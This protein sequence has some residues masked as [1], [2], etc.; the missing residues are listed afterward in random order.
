[1]EF[2]WP[3][4]LLNF[5]LHR[6]TIETILFG[7]ASIRIVILHSTTQ[8]W[9]YCINITWSISVLA[10]CECA[11]AHLV[12]FTPS[13]RAA[14]FSSRIFLYRVLCAF[15]KRHWDSTRSYKVC[16]KS[17]INLFLVLIGDDGARIRDC[18]QIWYHHKLNYG[19]SINGDK[20]IH[21]VN[22][23]WIFSAQTVLFFTARAPSF[24]SKILGF[25]I[26]PKAPTPNYV[27]TN[28]HFTE[29]VYS[30]RVRNCLHRLCAQITLK[31]A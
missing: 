27:R 15:L 5:M 16:P 14:H 9:T 12:P 17:S 31:R 7:I 8:T 24:L 11:C 13:Q 1:M 19:Q 25:R 28:G 29:T 26:L 2:S 30:A 18:Y 21:C 4:W 10:A 6:Q 22:L 20:K 23:D 3:N